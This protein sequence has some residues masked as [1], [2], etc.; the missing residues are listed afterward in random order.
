[1][2]SVRSVGWDSVDYH[3]VLC[4]AGSDFLLCSDIPPRAAAQH[5]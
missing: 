5:P 1:M 2:M 3:L 4:E